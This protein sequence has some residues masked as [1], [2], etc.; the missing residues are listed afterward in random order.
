[1][2]FLVR[3]ERGSLIEVAWA[4]ERDH[5][6]VA[7][8]VMEVETA[9]DGASAHDTLALQA[10]ACASAYRRQVHGRPGFVAQIASAAH[11]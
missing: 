10:F 5:H 2:R 6:P 3:A 9:G 11:R 4:V 8:G 1:M 7:V